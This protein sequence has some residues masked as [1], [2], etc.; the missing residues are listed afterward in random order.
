MW[1]K[2]IV[3]CFNKYLFRICLVSKRWNSLIW[4]AIDYLRVVLRSKKPLDQQITHLTKFT[5]LRQITLHNGF[6]SPA[7]IPEEELVQ[8]TKLSKLSSIKFDNSFDLCYEDWMEILH[9]LPSLDS[10]SIFETSKEAMFTMES[11]LP[12]LTM[13]TSLKIENLPD[14]G[15]CTI[16]AL[17]NLQHLEFDNLGYTDQEMLDHNGKYPYFF[18]TALQKLNTLYL[19]NLFKWED[20]LTNALLQISTLQSIELYP[21]KNM[22]VFWEQ[23]PRLTSIMHITLTEF[24]KTPQQVVALASLP[25]LQFVTFCQYNLSTNIFDQAQCTTLKGKVI[26]NR[27][28]LTVLY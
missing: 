24:P 5:N 1:R 22:D 18:L 17:T 15:I 12:T 28:H 27:K 7:I 25:N 3:M 16:V 21:F 10:L 20:S 13:L 4:I 9:G 26:G 11:V 6:Y 2:R 14:L 19:F 23:L 8:L